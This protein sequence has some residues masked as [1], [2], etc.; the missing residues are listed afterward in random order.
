VLLEMEEAPGGNSRSGQNEI[1]AY[2]WAA[3]YL[4]VPGPKHGLVHA[5]MKELGAFDGVEWQERFLCFS[6]QERLFLH[7]RWEED[8]TP[9]HRASAEWARFE[10]LIAQERATGQFTIPMEAG[11]KPSSLDQISMADWLARNQLESPYLR[12]YVDYA[13]RDDYGCK[14]RD[15][16]AWAGIHYF[17]SRGSDAK[18]PL[19]WPEGNAWIT[20]QLV[21]RLKKFIQ[22]KQPVVSILRSGKSLLVA[23]PTNTY[24]TRAVIFAAPTFL[25]HYLVEDAPRASIEYSPWVTA[26]LTLEKPPKGNGVPPAWDNVIYNSPSLGYVVATH[27]SLASRTDR[28]VWTWYHALAGSN[29]AADRRFLL[30][31]DWSFWRNFILDDLAKAHPDIRDCVSHI[32]VMRMGHA[33]ARPSP[34]AMFDPKRRAWS[35]PQNGIFYACSDLSGFSVFEEAQYR[36]VV[37]ADRALRAIQ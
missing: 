33:M 30:E 17:A 3:H 11:C 25:A 37:A 1:T 31:K 35:K 19:T 26:N 28:S 18:G 14:A 15:T 32:D 6:P 29:P 16:S 23:T 7:G 34:G 13:C 5:L 36:G 12:W 22:T 21:A 20:N 24:R 27:M 8:L 4:P 10:S 9:A 2:P